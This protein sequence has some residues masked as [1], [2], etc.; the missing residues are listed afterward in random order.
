MNLVHASDSAENATG[1]LALWFS[2]D[3]LIDYSRS[4][5]SWITED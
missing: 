2:D 4:V 5:D 3:E 1:E